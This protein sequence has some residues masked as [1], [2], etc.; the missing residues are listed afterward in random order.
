MMKTFQVIHITS[1][2]AYCRDR[3]LIIAFGQ[4]TQEDFR[5]SSQEFDLNWNLACLR[6]CQTHPGDISRPE[7]NGAEQAEYDYDDVQEVGED[8][9]PLVAQ[10]IYH[11]TLQHADLR[12]KK[13]SGLEPT[14]RWTGMVPFFTGKWIFTVKPPRAGEMEDG[15][16]AVISLA[17]LLI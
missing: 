16:K 5:Q 7:L 13:R 12:R 1:Q 14:C 11:L 8:G 15:E 4:T 17:L 2:A 3:S 9:S 10:K 6:A